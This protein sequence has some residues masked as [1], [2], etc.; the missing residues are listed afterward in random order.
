MKLSVLK[1]NQPIQEIDLGKDVL[2]HDYSETIFLIGRSKDCHIVL[3]DK[4][5]SREHARI[6]HKSGKWFIE[7]TNPDNACQINGDD[8]ERHELETGDVFTAESFSVTVLSDG[9]EA[10]GVTTQKEVP[11][12]EQK[13]EKVVA[14][15][16]EQKE[17]PP[18]PV[19]PAKTAKSNATA[20][21]LNIQQLDTVDSS[22]HFDQDSTK[23]IGLDDMVESSGEESE[24]QDQP[25]DDLDLSL[26]GTPRSED[27][28]TI[29]SQETDADFVIA[30][31]DSGEAPV[32]DENMSYSLE[33]ID[34]GSDDEST[35][36]I[37][38]FASVY[39]ELFGDTAPYDRY[40][41]EN[42]KTFIGRDPSKCQI[43]LNDSEVSTVHAVITKNNIMLSLE[44]LNSSNGTLHKGD[45]INK[46]MLSHNDEFVIG[47]VTFTVKI[48]SEFLKE[49]SAT[50]MAVDEN[51]TVEVEEVVE[52]ELEEGEQL[53]ALGEAVSAEPEEKSII[54]R[55]LKDEQKRKKALYIIV[56]L[57]AAWFLFGD[58]ETTAPVKQTKK[59]PA[60]KSINSPVTK[61][62]QKNLSEEQKRALSAQYEIGKSHFQEGRYREALTEL[63]KV[64]AVDPNFNS[65]L[66]SL[67]ALSKEGL[68]KIEEAEKERQAKLAAAEKKAKVTAL[69]EKAREYTKDRRVDLATSTFNEITQLDPENF[70][71]SK[72]K[73][74]L[75]DWQRE[76][77][78]KELE[79][80]Q[81]KKDRDDKVEKLKPARTLFLQNEW[82][83]AIN[84]L[85][86]FLRIKDMDDDLT[87]EATE[88][89]KKSKDELNSAVAPLIGKAKSLLEGQ[90]LKG[91]YEVYQ[92]ILRIEPS[93]SEALNQVGD[94]REQLATRARKIYREAIIAESLSLFQ[95]AK[96]KFQEVQQISPVDSDYYKKATEKLKDYLE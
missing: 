20:T 40:I 62:S 12:V 46:V 96:E 15:P 70:E 76:K 13:V 38:T 23:E 90:D 91:A 18:A 11:V 29:T 5:I 64:A 95:D 86:D 92:Q 50:L 6:I 82:F 32:E 10:T 28:S 1:R 79:E 27:A 77:Q 16:V 47:G 3:D 88:M 17:T 54:K 45:R 31:N 85:E 19:A 24:F 63:Q 48:R 84:K 35:K 68:G 61:V 78:R 74:E 22:V 69:L 26:G 34:G 42:E 75:D 9:T 89:L 80:A 66:Q 4:K 44:D 55:I 25:E 21:D 60:K 8:F 57:A 65:N 14:A 67:I 7:K 37:Q 49:E 53:D 56:A 41:I 72:M 87:T 2:A 93:N 83:K 94:I 71:V 52:E 39:L 58:E 59:A 36:V 30:E 43:V 81:K 51:Q 73:M 33:N